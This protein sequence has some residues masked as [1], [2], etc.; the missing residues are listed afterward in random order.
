MGFRPGPA[1]AAARRIAQSYQR[2]DIARN[3]RSSAPR[4]RTAVNRGLKP[5]RAA[6]AGCST[7]S[8]GHSA[9]VLR[10]PAR[11][12]RTA[13]DMIRSVGERAK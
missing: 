12:R 10:R 3:P 4:S 13:C 5:M 7:G 11:R 8:P 1:A 2:V 9:R 6:L